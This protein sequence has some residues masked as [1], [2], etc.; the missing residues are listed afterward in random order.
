MSY[1]VSQ[2]NIDA[3][4]TASDIGMRNFD[5]TL[6]L[7]Q[8]LYDNTFREAATFYWAGNL[9]SIEVMVPHSVCNSWRAPSPRHQGVMDSAIQIGMAAIIDDP[10]FRVTCEE[11]WAVRDEEGWTDRPA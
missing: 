5:I 9:S 1:Q 7:E 2:A 10:D 6:S 8:V 4:R 11:R 3:F